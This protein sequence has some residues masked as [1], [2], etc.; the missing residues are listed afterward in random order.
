MVALHARRLAGVAAA[1]VGLLGGVAMA[2][3]DYSMYLGFTGGANIPSTYATEKRD[4][5][6]LPGE[7]FDEVDYNLDRGYAFSASVGTYIGSFRLELQGATQEN[8][9]DNVDVL[10]LEVEAD[11][12]IWSSQFMANVLYDIPLS[13]RT[14]AFVGAGL[15]VAY[16][17]LNVDPDTGI[18]HHDLQGVGFAYQG[19]VGLA[20]QI[21]QGVSITADYRLWTST[22]IESDDSTLEMPVFHMVEVGVRFSF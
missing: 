14:T 11:G 1:W 6:G 3:D 7:W 13:K 4:T 17:D 15:G 8:T 20:W 18:D 9:I 22:D 21:A 5:E 10:G 12:E 2:A 16:V 19:I